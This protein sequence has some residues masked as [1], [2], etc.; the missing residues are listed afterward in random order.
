MSFGEWFRILLAGAVGLAGLL[1]AR[2][3]ETALTTEQLGLLIFAL[4]V[5]YVFLLVSRYFDW[6]DRTARD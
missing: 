1:L 6:Q 4:A 3:Q 2:R 5:A